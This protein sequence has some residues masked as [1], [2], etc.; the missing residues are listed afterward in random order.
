MQK[1]TIIAFGIILVSFAIGA[2]VYSQMPDVMAS[3][4]NDKGE[5]NGYMG[6]FW[7]VF[8]MP[9]LSLFML[10]LFILIPKIDPLKANIAGFR[11]YYNTF[12]VLLLV[13][14]FYIYGL[15]LA[16]NLGIRYNM[17]LFLVPALA[18]L[19][20]YCG[21]LVENAKMNWF[22]GI[23]TPWT[24]S[25]SSV[26]DKTHRLGGRLFKLA[27]LIALLG[28]VAPDFAMWLVIVPVLIFSIW[29][30]VYSYLEFKK[31]T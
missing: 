18:I 14:L 19:Y 20:Y 16:W 5:V 3:H 24:L 26:W 17:I 1:A 28:V 29:S 11:K 6:K 21:V 12:I 10:F 31:E 30:T 7:G 8:M 27:G 13:F 9:I 22:I 25:S 15:T 4:W 23:K 2:C